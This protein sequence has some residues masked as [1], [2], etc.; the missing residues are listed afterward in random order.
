MARLYCVRQRDETDCGAA[1]LA[2]I[3]Q[4]YGSKQPLGRVRAIAGTDKMGTSAF[5][6]VKAAEQLGF[7][8]RGVRGSMEAL[9]KADGLPLPAIAHMVTPEGML[10]YVVIQ[11]VK[12]GV[13][14]IADPGRGLRKLTSD[15]FAKMWTGV[16][17][18]LAPATDG[19]VQGPGEESTLRRFVGLLNGQGKFLA[20]M[21]VA[22][23]LITVIGI[24]SAFYFK[25]IIDDIVPGGL[26]STLVTLSLGLLG[27]YLINQ[28]LQAA[29]YQLVLHLQQRID[30]PLVLG[31]YNH[32]V[33]LPMSFFGTRRTGEIITRFSDAS[34]IQTALTGATV[35]VFVDVIMSIVS[36]IVLATQDKMLFLISLVIAVGNII[37]GLVMLRPLRKL[38]MEMMESNAQVTSHFVET[39]SMAETVK[40]YNAQDIVKNKADSLYV[41]FLRI[42]FRFGQWQ[43]MQSVVSGGLRSIGTLVVMWVGTVRILDN[44]FTIGGLV[45]FTSLLSYFLDPVQRLMG[46]QPDLQSA[47]VAARRLSDVLVLDPEVVE[48]ET[49]IDL[50]RIDQP[51][52]LDNV[53]FRYGTRQK[54][55]EQVSLTI[56]PGKTVGLVGESGSGKTTIAKLLLKFYAPEGGLIRFGDMVSED[57]SAESL[58]ERIAYVA[59]DTGFFSGTIEENLKLAKPEATPEEMIQACQIAQAHDFIAA[60]PARYQSYLEEGAANLSGGQRQRLAI[61]R[62]LL[63]GA[64]MLI[65][66]EATSNMD[67][68]SERAVSETIHRLGS[69]VTSLVIAHRLSTVVACDIIYVMRAGRIV[70]SGTHSELLTQGGA[71]AQ[72]WQAQ[73]PVPVTQAAAQSLGYGVQPAIPASRP[74]VP[75]KTIARPIPTTTPAQTA[76]LPTQ[77]AVLPAQ[78]APR[79]V[80][81]TPAVAPDEPA[82]PVSV[83]PAAAEPEGTGQ[84]SSNSPDFV[85]PGSAHP[86]LR[87]ATTGRTSQPAITTLRHPEVASRP[88][89][90]LAPFGRTHL[91]GQT[92]SDA[93]AVIGAGAA[94]VATTPDK[95]PAPQAEAIPAKQPEPVPEAPAQ[96]EPEPEAVE[97]EAESEA[98]IVLPDDVPPDLPRELQ[99]AFASLQAAMDAAP[100][101]SAPEADLAEPAPS[102]P[103]PSEP[104]PSEATAAAEEP[105]TPTVQI[106]PYAPGSTPL[107][108][109]AFRKVGPPQELAD[110]LARLGVA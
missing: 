20:L 48:S 57:I 24:V 103:A 106:Q 4:Q 14:T 45:V 58:R 108:V 82:A 18:I 53:D 102:E 65:L 54:V 13:I 17:I 23:A 101:P 5:G 104:E 74:V 3:C 29:R 44:D 15:E 38:N 63:R 1:C 41:S 42:I 79:P 21:T 110:R 60:M 59:Q 55:L 50:K 68:I 27:M 37:L 39:I 96:P 33:G 51:I 84:P 105:E 98:P 32:V 85:R 97:P 36:C 80:R 76:V 81:T 62:A 30:I 75:R 89:A 100:E 99:Q 72:L 26:R 8:A 83:R 28:L 11:R 43:N 94:A 35:T 88:A 90:H 6:L 12:N 87:S 9:L 73:S 49:Q 91:D 40:A 86:T 56:P 47:A 69:G 77:T 71:Y 16:L 95:D 67:S 107:Q 46:L 34:R 25:V 31:Y 70:E 52:V 7:S 92:A 22:S 109:A 2:T 64:D 93:A 61:A 78:A 10:H 19:V 66:D